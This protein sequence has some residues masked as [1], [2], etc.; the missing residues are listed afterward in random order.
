MTLIDPVTCED[1]HFTV[2]GDDVQSAERWNALQGWVEEHFAS[3]VVRADAGVPRDPGFYHDT[4]TG[5]VMYQSLAQVFAATDLQNTTWR[6]YTTHPDD[7]GEDLGG[8]IQPGDIIGPWLF[9]DLQKV[10]NVLVWTSPAHVWTANSA[11]NHGY[12]EGDDWP[13]RQGWWYAVNEANGAWAESEAEG[14]APEAVTAGKLESASFYYAKLTRTIARGKLASLWTGVSRAVEWYIKTDKTAGGWST[15][16][17]QGDTGIL[18][19]KYSLWL[20]DDPAPEDETILS[21][22]SIGSELAKPAYWKSAPVGVNWEE[23]GWVTYAQAVVIRWD[24]E[25]GFGLT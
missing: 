20:T 17:T 5:V 16:H 18:Q 7:E 21:S 8:K 3:F 24:V 23:H 11:D 1:K 19:G 12:G 14:V 25:N 4:T 22:V 10:L 13:G 9:E 15:W 6:R 2:E